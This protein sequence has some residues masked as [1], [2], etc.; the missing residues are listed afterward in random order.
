MSMLYLLK[1]H[2][3]QISS[4]PKLYIE[5][6]DLTLSIGKHIAILGKNGVGKSVFLKQLIR[7]I[8][9]NDAQLKVAYANQHIYM[10][11]QLTWQDA[12][13]LIKPIE[14]WQDLLNHCEYLSLLASIKDK[15]IQTLSG[16]YQQLFHVLLTLIEDVDLIV[17]DEPFNHLDYWHYKQILKLCQLRMQNTCMISTTH[18]FEYLQNVFTDYYLLQAKMHENKNQNQNEYHFFKNIL[19]NTQ[20]LHCL[21]IY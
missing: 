3:Y 18:R 6:I 17:L 8:A 21:T 7:T 4:L 13:H 1:Q 10:H 16:G 2:D 5:S 9:L 19:T 15:P 20:D 12:I 11:P 14:N